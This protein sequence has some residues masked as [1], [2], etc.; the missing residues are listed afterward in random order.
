MAVRGKVTIAAGVPAMTFTLANMPGS[1]CFVFIVED[2][3]ARD[4]AAVGATRA[5]MVASS[6]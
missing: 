6:R 2:D 3:R 4:V 1:N 5:S